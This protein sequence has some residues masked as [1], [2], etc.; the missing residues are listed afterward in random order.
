M[1]QAYTRDLIDD[2]RAVI[3]DAEALLSATAGDVSE[4]AQQAHHK[5]TESVERARA[6]LK[7]LEGDLTAKA[8]AMADDATEYVS[9][10]PWQSVGIAAAIGVV[11]GVLLA[12]R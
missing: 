11:I 5:A 2:L 10:N 3:S 9:D 6:N 7:Q 1:T 8:K 4:R 12:R